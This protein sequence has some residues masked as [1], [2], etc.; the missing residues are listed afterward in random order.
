M[1]NVTFVLSL[2]RFGVP[3]FLHADEPLLEIIQHEI[4]QAC[5]P[6]FQVG[7]SGV[8]AIEGTEKDRLARC[9]RG[10]AWPIDEPA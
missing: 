8:D 2:Y 10:T 6:Y 4:T 9:C 7:L 5:F 1:R 3:Q